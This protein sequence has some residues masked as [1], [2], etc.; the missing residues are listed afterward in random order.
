MKTIRG[1]LGKEVCQLSI[2]L[3]N[4]V[5]A[6]LDIVKK[7]NDEHIEVLALSVLDSV[8]SAVTRMLVSDPDGVMRIF[9]QTGIAYAVSNVLVVELS[10]AAD[11]AKLLTC[12]LMAEVNVNFSYPLMTQPVGK[13]ALVLHVEDAECAANV[14]QMHGFRLLRQSDLSR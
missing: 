13:P 1:E 7:L 10:G 14:M 9:D 4:R 12:V 6:L 8:D 11:L 2:F 3:Q 5:G